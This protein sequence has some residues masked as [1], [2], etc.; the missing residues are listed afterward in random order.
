MPIWSSRA[1]ASSSTY[2]GGC[3]CTST[4]LSSRRCAKRYGTPAVLTWEGEISD[5]EWAIATHN[6]SRTHE[7]DALHPRPIRAARLDSQ[8]ALRRRR[9]ASARRRR[10]AGRGLRRRRGARGA[11]GDGPARR[12]AALSSSH[13]RSCSATRAASCRGRTHVAAG[14]DEGPRSFRPTTRR[15]SP[16]PAGAPSP[17]WQARCA[18]AS[19]PRTAPF[20]RYPRCVARRSAFQPWRLSAPGAR[21]P[22]RDAYV[23][24]AASGAARA[25]P[26]IT[27][28]ARL[29]TPVPG[30][31]LAPGLAAS[32]LA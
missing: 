25:R 11:R 22:C 6:P 8:A 32:Y 15:R 13:R 27:V 23:F 1:P 29:R 24:L 31:G 26:G 2:C 17:S 18:S 5:I 14:A 16:T 4:R 28:H 30:P 10:Q 12:A 21:Q 19:W 7:R 3:R 9:V 20:W